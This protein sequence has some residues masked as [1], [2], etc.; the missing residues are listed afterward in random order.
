ML[1]IPVHNGEPQR[2]WPERYLEL[3]INDQA[4]RGFHI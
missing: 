4:D 1:P 2:S 3:H